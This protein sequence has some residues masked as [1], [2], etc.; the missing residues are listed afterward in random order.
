MD[1][2]ERILQVHK[3]QKGDLGK[4]GLAAEWSKGI[5]DKLHGKGQSIQ[6]LLCLHLSNLQESHPLKSRGKVWSKED[7]LSVKEAQIK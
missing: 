7:L 6:H 2:K 3:W 1:V 4:H 5:C